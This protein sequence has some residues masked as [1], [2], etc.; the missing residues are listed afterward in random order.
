MAA[1]GPPFAILDT[2]TNLRSVAFVG[3]ADLTDVQGDEDNEPVVA[4]I[5]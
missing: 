3:A 5:Q 4:L 2:M 1:H